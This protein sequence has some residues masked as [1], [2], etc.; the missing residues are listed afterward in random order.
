M[1]VILLEQVS[2]LV[3]TRGNTALDRELSRDEKRTALFLD[4]LDALLQTYRQR[5]RCME[6]GIAYTG[7]L[8][9]DW[10]PKIDMNNQNPDAVI[11]ML[12]NFC[13]NIELC[14]TLIQDLHDADLPDF[15]LAWKNT[16]SEMMENDHG[17]NICLTRSLIVQAGK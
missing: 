1:S 16:L 17:I 9:S 3:W 13:V 10:C 6:C 5:V 2:P 11:R 14:M 15:L 8:H 12:D 7:D 4:Y